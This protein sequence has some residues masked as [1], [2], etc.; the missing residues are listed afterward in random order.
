[1]S[2]EKEIASRLI[3]KSNKLVEAA[4]RLSLQE[5]RVILLM[6]AMINPGDEDFKKYVFEVTEL[7]KIIGFKG[8]SLYAEAEKITAR[9]NTRLIEIEELDSNRLLQMSWVSSAEYFRNEGYVEICFDPKLKPYLLKMKEKFT[10]YSLLHA[11]RFRSTYSLRIYELLKSY[12][13]LGQRSFLLSDLRRILGIDEDEYKLYAD[14][15]RKVI[16]HACNEINNKTDLRV[17][18]EVQKK[19]KSVNKIKFLIN[20]EAE[21]KQLP[22]P[23]QPKN[24]ELYEVLIKKFSQN[25]K[26]AREYLETYSETQILA[27]L[28]HVERRF[29]AGEVRNIGAYTR[30]AISDDIRDQ[31]SLFEEEAHQFARKKKAEAMKAH[32]EDRSLTAWYLQ[33][34]EIKKKMDRNEIAQFQEMA[35]LQIKEEFGDDTKNVMIPTPWINQ[36][37]DMLI[38]AAK[39]LVKPQGK[40]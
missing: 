9:L 11:M 24:P 7:A 40:S 13:G 32:E 25:P 31:L 6:T 16:D 10:R 23:K 12:E 4:H 38:G 21:P 22:L 35:R 28:K 19:G 33:I 20:T 26:Q 27:N 30:K 18:Y 39:G 2:V 5:Q 36:R 15:R 29:K 17:T 8:K 34:E 1:M 37:A 3:C 14:F